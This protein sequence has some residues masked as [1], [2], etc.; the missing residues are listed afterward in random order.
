MRRI[1]KIFGSR[2]VAENI[3]HFKLGMFDIYAELKN[4]LSV[5]QHQNA[6]VVTFYIPRSQ[7]GLFIT[8][9]GSK[10]KESECNGIL[11]YTIHQTN[12]WGLNTAKKRIE[13][14]LS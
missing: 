10:F 11:T 4:E 3:T 12:S 2:A 5:W 14:M 6:E 9:K 13:K 7:L 8:N 1:S